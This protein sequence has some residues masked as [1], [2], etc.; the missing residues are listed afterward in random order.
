MIVFFSGCAN[1]RMFAKFCIYTKV[2]VAP[3]DRPQCS[4]VEFLKIKLATNLSP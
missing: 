1:E 2:V 4:M 3:E